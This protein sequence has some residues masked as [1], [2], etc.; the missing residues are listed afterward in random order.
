[1]LPLRPKRFFWRSRWGAPIPVGAAKV[2]P[3]A[4]LRVNATWGD[5]KWHHLNGGDGPDVEP[6]LPPKPLLLQ[7]SVKVQMVNR[8]DRGW[9]RTRR[10]VGERLLAEHAR[11][12]CRRAMQLEHALFPTDAE[13]GNL[14]HGCPLIQ[15]VLRHHEYGTSRCRQGRAA[16]SPCPPTCKPR[17]P[18]Y[19]FAIIAETSG[20]ALLIQHSKPTCSNGRLFREPCCDRSS[21]AGPPL[22]SSYHA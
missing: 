21:H 18:C 7:T 11:P 12:V 1:M 8:F 3:A 19:P 16:S 14:S 10:A 22:T 13:D 5:Q 20:G 2:H 6:S 15:L 4:R 9:H 17:S